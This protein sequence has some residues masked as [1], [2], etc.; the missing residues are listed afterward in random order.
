MYDEDQL[1]ETFFYTRYIINELPI[2]FI[3]RKRLK[4][5]FSY[6]G[7]KE[8]CLLIVF[9]KRKDYTYAE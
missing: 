5:R 9:Y 8:I 1:A 3:N 2:M 4:E 7:C 6:E